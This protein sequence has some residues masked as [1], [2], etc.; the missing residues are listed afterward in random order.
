MELANQAPPPPP[1]PT[2]GAEVLTVKG[3]AR[4]KLD[5]TLKVFILTRHRKMNG[6][7]SNM[8]PLEITD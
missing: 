4:K 7:Q 8:V 2:S 1:S 5:E 6:V 3:P